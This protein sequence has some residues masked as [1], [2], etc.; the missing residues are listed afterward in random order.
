MRYEELKMTLRLTAPGFHGEE[1]KIAILYLFVS[2]ITGRIK[3]KKKKR[4]GA[5][6]KLSKS[7]S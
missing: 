2:I 4:L 5:S 6:R 7:P 3:R 1:L